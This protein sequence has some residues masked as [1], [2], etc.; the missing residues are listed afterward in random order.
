MAGRMVE[1]D[2]LQQYQAVNFTFSPVPV[3]AYLQIM[4]SLIQWP[5]VPTP[6]APMGNPDIKALVIGNLYD[7]TTMYEWSQKMHLSFPKGVLMTW[8]GI[9]HGLLGSTRYGFL[10]SAACEEH[11]FYYLNT[12]VLPPNGFS[13]RLEQDE[14]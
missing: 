5:V 2:F 11:A 1:S 7:P 6:V 9:G 4:T 12:G 8:Q 13:C 10:G 14:L 3:W